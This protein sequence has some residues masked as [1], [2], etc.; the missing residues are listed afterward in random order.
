MKAAKSGLSLG[1]NKKDR[2]TVGT[3]TVRKGK[4]EFLKKVSTLTTATISISTVSHLEPITGTNN[5]FDVD[6]EIAFGVN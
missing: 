1:I 4:R 3:A 5:V 2:P 6:F